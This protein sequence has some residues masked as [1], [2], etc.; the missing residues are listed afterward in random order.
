MLFLIKI[1]IC[2]TEYDQVDILKKFYTKRKF[3]LGMS[4]VC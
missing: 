4:T 1:N 3:W 2:H